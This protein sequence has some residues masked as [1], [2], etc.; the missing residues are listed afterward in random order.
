MGG[1]ESRQVNPIFNSC[2][3]GQGAAGVAGGVAG[4]DVRLGG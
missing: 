1:G 2:F 4:L 3:G